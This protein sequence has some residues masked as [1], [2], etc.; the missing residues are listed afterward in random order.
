MSSDFLTQVAEWAG[1]DGT[2]MLT[3]GDIFRY[4]LAISKESGGKQ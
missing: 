1:K 4:M 2:A 3:F